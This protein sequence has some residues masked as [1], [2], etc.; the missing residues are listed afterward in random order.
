MLM[1]II[2]WLTDLNFKSVQAKKLSKWVKDTGHWFLGS[3]QFQQWVDGS[4]AA[5]CL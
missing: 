1:H 4:V 2:T 5:S 3:E